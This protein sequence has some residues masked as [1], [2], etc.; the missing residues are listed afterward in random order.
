MNVELLKEHIG[1]FKDFDA[2]ELEE[3]MIFF[4]QVALA[5][6]AELWTYG[7]G[8]KHAGFILNGKIVVRKQL[9][10]S[11]Q[12]VILGVYGPGSII[13]ELSLLSERPPTLSAK[14]LEHTDL[15]II[16]NHRFMELLERKPRLGLSL[17]RQL[18]IC[19]AKRLDKSYDRITSMF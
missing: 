17:I 10:D 11:K 7:D 14:A 3:A 12:H 2:V 5:P 15:V 4:D 9:N 16:E 18:Y 8:K 1:A 6:G 19:T 13:G